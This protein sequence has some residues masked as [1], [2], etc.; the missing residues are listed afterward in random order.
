M[1]FVT[2]S[3]ALFGV[4]TPRFMQVGT[5]YCRVTRSDSGETAADMQINRRG[6]SGHSFPGGL[7]MFARVL[8]ANWNAVYD[9]S[10][11]A[12]ITMNNLENVNPLLT[13]REDEVAPLVPGQQYDVYCWGK[14]PH[15]GCRWG[16]C[17][18]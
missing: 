10:S 11:N 15:V 13:N 18:L 8:T 17:S 1:P 16:F 5:A 14:D 4:E 2:N 12:T 7:C 9:G 6:R 3:D